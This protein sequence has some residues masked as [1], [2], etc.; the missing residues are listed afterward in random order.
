MSYDR[1]PDVYFC[2]MTGN[3][4]PLLKFGGSGI[5]RKVQEADAVCGI[6]EF[7]RIV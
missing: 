2:A 7:D 4:M 1:K 3:F 5:L 6:A